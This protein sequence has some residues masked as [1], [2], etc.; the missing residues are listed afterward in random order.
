[1]AS[2]LRV[3]DGGFSLGFGGILSWFLE[4]ISLI[5]LCTLVSFLQFNWSEVD[6]VGEVS[7]WVLSLVL[8]LVDNRN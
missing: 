3:V 1:M 4:Y 6:L 2:G 5:N 8:G 7:G